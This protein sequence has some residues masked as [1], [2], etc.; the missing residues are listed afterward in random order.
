MST[1]TAAVPSPHIT[2]N[3]N[4]A[5][6]TYGVL[7]QPNTLTYYKD[8]VQTYSTPF[9]GPYMPNTV[10][11]TSIGSVGGAPTPGHAAGSWNGSWILYDGSNSS[12][13]FPF[14]FQY[15]HYY[16]P[17]TMVTTAVP[18][19]SNAIFIDRKVP[20]G[21]SSTFSPHGAWS[22]YTAG[23]DS[24]TNITF[25]PLGYLGQN[26]VTSQS[27]GD[28]AVWS[29]T[30]SSTDAGSYDVYLW[31]AA[32]AYY[33][34]PNDYEGQP[35]FAP[36][37]AQNT[38]YVLAGSA[39]AAPT[40]QGINQ[41]TAGQQWVPVNSSG[42]S[43]NTYLFT[44]GSVASITLT[45]GTE[46]STSSPGGV[47]FTP[48]TN[49]DSVVFIPVHTVGISPSAPDSY[50]ESGMTSSGLVGWP[51]SG[52]AQY[53][54]RSGDPT[55]TAT[56]SAGLPSAGGSYAI[57]V[58]VPSSSSSSTT[59]YYVVYDGSTPLANATVNQV[60][61]AGQWVQ[62]GTAPVTFSGTTATITVTNGISGSGANGFL[63]TNA[64]KLVP[65]ALPTYVVC[66]NSK[67]LYGTPL[68]STSVGTWTSGTS[69]VAS[70]CGTSDQLS[71]SSGATA[72]FAPQVPVAGLYHA[73]VFND[74]NLTPSATKVI[75]AAHASSTMICNALSNTGSSH[76]IYLGDYYFG[77]DVF[78][79]TSG[80][81]TTDTI[82]MKSTTAGTIAANAIQLV[83]ATSPG[84][85]TKQ[86]TNTP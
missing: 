27:P 41:S 71:T 74:S 5:P 81:M 65:Q 31:N 78:P 72:T 33:Q 58:Y 25:G 43:T 64:I 1:D 23:V 36:D 44:G 79:N 40:S 47:A 7:V 77:P 38:T 42:P 60:T 57:Y 48:H 20:T 62:I 10:D 12:V 67:S 51:G 30:F 34:I 50:T 56:W 84:D 73:Y 53:S 3:N 16:Q 83:Y 8:G 80:V 4:L 49:A 75:V 54:T 66:T 86:C 32:T 21:L 26:A 11:F 13:T 2:I 85:P 61:Q 37:A 28:Q 76:W 17:T 69:S 22:N 55:A 29:H 18:I 45:V 52:A 19:P 68:F 46:S 70:P 39:G 63:R 59:A 6:H 14:T 82:Q 35:D 24:N 15:F 9:A